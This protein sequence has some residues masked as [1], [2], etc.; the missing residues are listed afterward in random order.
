MLCNEQTNVF[1]PQILCLF[2]QYQQY[3]S[4][5]YYVCALSIEYG[6]A[7]LW[8]DACLICNWS[9][10]SFLLISIL[11]P[12]INISLK[13]LQYV[14][15]AGHNPGSGIQG[16]HCS[17]GSADICRKQGWTDKHTCYGSGHA[18]VRHVQDECH[19]LCTTAAHCSST[20]IYSAQHWHKQ[21]G[22][23]CA[24]AM[25]EKLQ[26]HRDL[27]YKLGLCTLCGSKCLGDDVWLH[28]RSGWV[29]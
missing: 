5:T 16:A 4:I 7:L 14:N 1:L 26:M 11:K 22:Q 24:A 29:K 19:Q 17:Y 27:Q 15:L 21:T 23:H 20:W 10:M 3:S 18:T 6:D 28:C 12:H 8:M 13:G 2:H 9:N 25:Q